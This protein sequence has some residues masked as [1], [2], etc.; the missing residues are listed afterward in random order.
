[1]FDNDD[2]DVYAL[3]RGVL[4]ERFAEGVLDPADSA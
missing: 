4:G 2:T 3:A 1:V